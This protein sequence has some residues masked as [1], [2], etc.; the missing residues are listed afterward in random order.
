MQSSHDDRRLPVNI[1]RTVDDYIRAHIAYDISV[2]DIA[3]A[4]GYNPA[5]FSQI[6]K[7]T[8]GIPPYKYL[9]NRRVEAVRESLHTTARLA[10]IALATGF[11]N[12]EHMTRMF[13]KFHGIS[14]SHYRRQVRGGV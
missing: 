1:L 5:Y 6:F 13:R 12:Q 11:C 2:T 4:A 3:Q 7:R 8:L 9:L 10:D 14:P